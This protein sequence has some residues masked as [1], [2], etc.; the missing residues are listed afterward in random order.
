LLGFGEGPMVRRP[1][2]Y[3]NPSVQS[4]SDFFAMLKMVSQASF[5]SRWG[6]PSPACRPNSAGRLSRSVVTGGTPE[7]AYKR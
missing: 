4:V 7:R 3:G 6:I 1:A 2:A 5:Q